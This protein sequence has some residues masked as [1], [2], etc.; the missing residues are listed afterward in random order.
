MLRISNLLFDY[1]H[2]AG[3]FQPHSGAE[4]FGCHPQITLVCMVILVS[5]VDHVVTHVIAGLRTKQYLDPS[6]ER[7]A[8]IDPDRRHNRT[9]WTAQNCQYSEYNNSVPDEGERMVYKPNKPS[10]GFTIIELIAVIIVLAIL[11]GIAI[12]KYFDWSEDAETSSDEGS[13]SGIISALHLVYLD[14]R[15]LSAQSNEWIT[16]IDQVPSVMESGELPDGIELVQIGGGDRIQDR[17]G[18]TYTF[19]AESLTSPARLT[20]DLQGGGG[21]SGSSGSSS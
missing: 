17:R 5:A 4:S 9:L 20:Q 11:S 3:R 7:T 1:C 14:H 19:V 8:S 13:I 15:A 21:S 12:P 2:R 16:S 18:N 6:V 10:R